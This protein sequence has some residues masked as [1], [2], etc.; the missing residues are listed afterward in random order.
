MKTPQSYPARLKELAGTARGDTAVVLAA[1]DGSEPELSW[2]ELDQWSTQMA[3]LLAAEGLGLGGRLAIE[4]PNG[5]EHVVAAFAGW[6][7]GA[8]VIPVRWDLPEWELQRVRHVLD[9]TVTLDEADVERLR[10]C[11]Q[12]AAEPLPDVIAPIAR[13]LCSSGSTGTP[14]IIVIDRPALLDGHPVSVTRAT[15]ESYGIRS[16]SQR[17]LVPGPLYHTVGMAALSHLLAGD[18]V[19]LFE[20]FDAVRALDIIERRRVNGF[21]AATIFLQR[22]VRVEGIEHRDLS[23]LLWVQQGAAFLPHWLARA[24]IALVG[25]T[26][27]FMSYGMTEGLGLC[28][29]RGDEWLE[30]AGSVGRPMGATAV[31]ILDAAGRDLPAGDV[32]EIYLHTPGRTGFH[33]VG[34][35]PPLPTRNDAGTTVGDL[36]WLDSD[37]YLY[38]VDRRADMIISGGANVF[39]AEVEAALSEHPRIA[40]VVVIGLSDPEWGRR[41][42]AIVVAG[43]DD[44]PPL[45]ADDVIAFAKSRLARYKV[46][47]TVEFVDVI[48][49]SAATKINRAAL[50]A[51]RQHTVAGDGRDGSAGDPARRQR[52][53]VATVDVED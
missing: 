7:L 28:A 37:G 1:L 39:P 11:R 20:K 35:V 40:D 19:I 36:G 33:Y 14:K 8:T 46:P 27:F 53:N 23:S 34:D 6:K 48:P 31:R 18:S 16:P 52:R 24:W 29:I 38:V 51:E 26:R 42:H 21:T 15:M 49:R 9:A 22:M 44:G 12:G 32:G 30:H 25:P 17:I 50:I 3:H 4:L 45:T 5:F 13:G 2:S 41:V 10:Q 47:K 43:D